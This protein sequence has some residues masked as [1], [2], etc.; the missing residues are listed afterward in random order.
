MKH[1]FW[2]LPLAVLM[3]SGTAE[4]RDDQLFFPLEQALSTDEAYQVINPDI[5]LY[6]AG[7]KAP[8]GR[9]IDT[10]VSNK[11]TNAVFK[12]DERACQWALYSALKSLQERAVKEGGNAVVNIESFYKKVPFRSATEYECHAGGVM[13]GVALRGTVIKR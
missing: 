4:A 12:S 7:Q 2:L 13:A 5:P 9:T 10:Y 8:G 11:K 3:M 6:F 1:A